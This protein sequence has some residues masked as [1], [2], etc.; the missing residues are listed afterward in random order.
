MTYILYMQIMLNFE[1]NEYNILYIACGI[2]NDDIYDNSM[3]N[4]AH[5]HINLLNVNPL[6]CLWLVLKFFVFT[7]LPFIFHF[8]CSC[9][10][11]FLIY[12]Y[13]LCHFHCFLVFVSFSFIV[14]IIIPLNFYIFLLILHFL[15]IFFVFFLWH[16]Y[17]K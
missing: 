3:W 6:H 7:S 11:F 4:L 15:N 5:S 13:I 12:M 10:L 16:G 1:S 9:I 14:I 2:I 8:Y 17:P